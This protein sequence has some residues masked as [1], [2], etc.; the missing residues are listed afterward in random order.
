VALRILR[1]V[2]DFAEVRAGGSIDAEVARD[3]LALLEIDDLGLD[4]LDRRVLSLLVHKFEG[5][6]VGVD[7]IAAAVGEETE[8]IEDVVEPY[9]LQLG[10]L[11]R[12]SRGRIATT[13]AYLHLAASPPWSAG[14]QRALFAR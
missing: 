14:A 3:A 1:R 2:R 7:T 10:F 11:E 5:G 6:P 4:E 13:A 8:T 12:T 9:L